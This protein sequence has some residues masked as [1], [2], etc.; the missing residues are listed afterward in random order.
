MTSLTSLTPAANPERL[1]GPLFAG[2]DTH[3][4]THHVAVVDGTGRPV[5]DRQFAT[6]PTGY[7]QVVAFLQLHGTVEQV[8]VEGTGS[9]GAGISRI[10]AA[11]GFTVMEIARPNRRHRRLKGKSDPIDAHQAALAVIAGTEA[12]IPK[13]GD[14]EV[15]SL[16]ILMSE[17]H[18]AVKARSQAMN[19]IH[20]LLVTAPDHVR[21]DYRAL[22]GE[23]LVAVLSRSR[24]ALGA[25]PAMVARHTLKRLAIRHTLL[26]D[27]IAVIDSQLDT[28]IRVL[29]PDLLALSGVG[30]VTATTLLTAA[31]DNPERLA[32]AAAF[33]AL[34]GAAPI[35]AS[36]GQRVRHRLSRGGNRKANSALH[37][38]VLLRMRHQEPRTAAYF[39]R[40]R[41]EGLSDR[42]IVRCL[43]RHIANEIFRVLTAP[44]PETPAGTLLR[45]RREELEIPIT[46]LAATLGVPYQ[47]LRRLETGTRGDTELEQKAHEVLNQIDP[48][49]AA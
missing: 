8:G 4:D 3:K 45:R 9:Y 40:R 31:G 12:G 48:P 36:S 5:A 30:V 37:R 49:K 26:R 18:S 43:K 25:D 24:P 42:D 19:Q 13:R 22:G 6:T 17:R 35:P 47:R 39:A 1:P 15:E 2:I 27:E 46:T 29:N 10:L 16:R 41:A 44:I 34:C 20:G 38:I 14:G 32:S 11:A 7:A 23:K 21:Q 28:L 33:A